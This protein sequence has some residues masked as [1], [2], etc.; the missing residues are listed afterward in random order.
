MDQRRVRL[1]DFVDDYCT[2]ERRLTNHTVVAMVGDEVKQTRCT[3]CD[4]EHPYR[5]AKV[6]PRRK[7]PAPTP[8]LAAPAPDDDSARPRL[9]GS[10]DEAAASHDAPT[11]ASVLAASGAGSPAAPSPAEGPVAAPVP[12]DDGPVHRRLIRATLPRIEGQVPTRQMPDFTLRLPGARLGPFR[13]GGGGG[14]SPQNGGRTGS[15][16][17]PQGGR[18]SPQRAGGQFAP[19]GSRQR[20][21][22]QG[23]QNRRPAGKKP[24]R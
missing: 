22:G 6:P 4:T 20:P 18:P 12:E 5:G 11:A 10:E 7:K 13:D 1:G 21:F 23:R 3:T 9:N 14:G 15:Y 2:R 24:S 16:G 19:P 8:A 17:R